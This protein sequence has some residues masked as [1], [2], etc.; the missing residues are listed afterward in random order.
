MFC[1]GVLPW[2]QMVLYSGS[3]RQAESI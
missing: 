1:I 2:L 3:G